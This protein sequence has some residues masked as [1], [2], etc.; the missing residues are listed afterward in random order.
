MPRCSPKETKIKFKK[1]LRGIH[2]APCFRREGHS[3]DVRGSEKT[4]ERR[5]NALSVICYG[6]GTG[7]SDSEVGEPP[8]GP[9]PGRDRLHKFKLW[10]MLGGGGERAGGK[11]RVCLGGW[12][13]GVASPGCGV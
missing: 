11:N 2:R 13:L 8:K 9:A 12:S 7:L 6:A 1:N 5:N 10:S 4:A 3:G